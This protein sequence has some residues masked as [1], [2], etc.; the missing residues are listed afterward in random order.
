MPTPWEEGSPDARIAFI[1]EA[2]STV[3]MRAGRPLV[4]P[5]G[6]VFEECLHSAGIVRRAVY[7][8]NTFSCPIK[9][10][11]D[12]ETF[13]SM[14]SGEPLWSASYGFTEA[15]LQHVVEL[16]KKL[17]LCKANVIVPLGATA[18]QAVHDDVPVMKWRGSILTAALI[19]RKIVP[20]IHPA[21]VLRGQP[22]WKYLIIH[23]FKRANEESN[24]PEVNLP[25]R[26]IYTN[27]STADALA[28]LE[29]AKK[30]EILA[31]DIEVYNHQ[32]S[33]FSIATSPS[34]VMSIPLIGEFGKDR[35]LQEEEVE[36]WRS[37]AEILGDEKIKKVNQNISFDAWF[38]YHQMGIFM[39]GDLEDT[40]VA[41]HIMYPD[42]PK[43]LD[44]ICSIHTREPYYKDDGKLWAKPWADFEKFWT[45]NAK[46]AAVAL[47]SWFSLEEELKKKGYW[48]NYKFTTSMIRPLIFMMTKGILVDE[49][50][51]A[52]I[53]EKTEAELAQEME[54]LRKVSVEPFDP[55][56]PKQ[57][58]RYFYGTLGLKPYLNHKTGRPTTDDLA[59]ARIIRRD[60]RPEARYVQKI[61]TLNKLI[62]S[63]LSV[64]LDKDKRMRCS[65]NIR[66]TWT[67]RLSSSKTIFNTGMNMQNIDSKFKGF[68]IPDPDSGSADD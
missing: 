27:P 22:T 50:A 32:V 60:N 9:K 49:K 54:N 37:Y 42:F 68:M 16:H 52:E 55:G 19:D 31:T 38:L 56:S 66:G 29:E 61:R 63:Y 12:G 46:D 62:D 45:Y 41:Q 14:E 11:R 21:A 15:G 58:Q 5:A 26:H 40:M 7:I 51:L 65:Y 59:L 23:D 34:E 6:L 13:Y 35:Y 43:G 10:D 64:Q 1:G 44:F 39:R 47:E 8:I 28:F 53:K 24:S 3:E 17:A 2:P 20:T 48:E 33:C 4:G 36:I 18:L 30:K 25:K 57:C 67:G